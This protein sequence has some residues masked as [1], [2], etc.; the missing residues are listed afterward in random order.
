MKRR[1][2]K[3]RVKKTPKDVRKKSRHLE[4]VTTIDFRDVGLLRRFVTEQGKIM[5]SRLLGTTAKQRR[6][7]ARAIS[8]ARAAGLMP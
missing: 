5:P 3:P 7:I 2:K 4:N 1:A 6:Q 8:R